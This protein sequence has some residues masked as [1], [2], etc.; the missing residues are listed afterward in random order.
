MR[1]VFMGTPVFARVALDALVAAG[2]DIVAVYSQ[3]PKPAGRGQKVTFT[4]V[5]ERAKALGIPVFTPFNFRS[6]E[7]RAHFA[8]HFTE[9]GA[10]V[11][12]V[13]AYGLILPQ[14]VLDVPRYGCLN[15]HASLLPRWRGAAPIQRAMLAGDG[16]T[17]ITIMQMEAGLDTGP[18][19]RKA[20]CAI[21]PSLTGQDLHDQLAVM[22]GALVCDVVAALA[23]DS[24]VLMTVQPTE[25][26]TYA[27]KLTR[28]DG[29][30]DW[31]VTGEQI[32]RQ[33]RAL[34]PW[35]GS[36]CTLS[37]AVA[38]DDKNSVLKILSAHFV[39]GEE[40][41][42]IPSGTILDAQFR[43]Q[44]KDGVLHVERVQA[45]GKP[46]MQAADYLRG[47]RLTLPHQLG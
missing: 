46:A 12:I 45:A 17:G 22:G 3:P 25:G 31:G 4:P 32:D 6:E 43:V 2:H 30:I 38:V 44:V 36:M 19:I 15:I 41:A 27:H 5:H 39:A 18:M 20:T 26:V 14:A 9:G 10:D 24:H 37:P 29:R 21:T 35:P 34:H 8:A 13:A 23:R 42:D 28:D 47:V 16:E 40:K 1:I 33:I 7:D 11:A